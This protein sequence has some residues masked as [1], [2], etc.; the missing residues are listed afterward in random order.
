[1]NP[2]QERIDHW[3]QVYQCTQSH[4]DFL[5]YQ[6]HIL[7]GETLARQA[8]VVQ[9]PVAGMN[10]MP[11]ENHTAK[12]KREIPTVHSDIWKFLNGI[13]NF[14]E[15]KATHNQKIIMTTR[16][17][18]AT[19]LYKI[20]VSFASM[21]ALKSKF[22]TK[23]WFFWQFKTL[24]TNY[25]KVVQKVQKNHFTYVVK[26]INALKLVLQDEIRIFDST[27]EIADLNIGIWD[28]PFDE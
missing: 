5:T 26:D 9:N 28:R 1:M 6:Y 7:L 17:I 8:S 10:P 22:E 16:G 25:P 4:I 13:L 24:C 15:T 27:I 18:T 20:F 12:K 23:T 21:N 11:L 3:R 14:H 19:L 2:N